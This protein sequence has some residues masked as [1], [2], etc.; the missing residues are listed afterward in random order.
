MK[1]DSDEFLEPKKTL[2]TLHKF[3]IAIHVAEE[4]FKN[5]TAS[6]YPQPEDLKTFIENQLYNYEYENVVSIAPRYSWNI[7]K[8]ICL[9]NLSYQMNFDNKSCSPVQ[10]CAYFGWSLFQDSEETI[11]IAEINDTPYERA[12]CFHWDEAKKNF[13]GKKN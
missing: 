5:G 4:A 7:W 8:N 13:F 12:A 1:A 10:L 2:L 9:R 3:K 11:H 6:T